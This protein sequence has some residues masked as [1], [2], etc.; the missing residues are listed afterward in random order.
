MKVC[1]KHCCVECITKLFL[2]HYFRNCVLDFYA[3]IYCIRNFVSINFEQI[4]LKCLVGFESTPTLGQILDASKFVLK[5]MI[6]DRSH[7]WHFGN[8]WMYGYCGAKGKLS[9]TTSVCYPLSTII[10]KV[11]LLL[12]SII[13]MIMFS[14]AM[15][16]HFSSCRWNKNFQSQC[17]L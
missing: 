6:Y 2:T 3:W 1:Y 8:R 12:L 15:E 5:A 11:K 14:V 10:P 9:D 7:P 16:P 4:H 17:L 13:L